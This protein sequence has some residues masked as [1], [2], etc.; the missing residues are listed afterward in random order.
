VS[1]HTLSLSLDH[2]ETDDLSS[3]F[4]QSVEAEV[5]TLSIWNVSDSTRTDNSWPPNATIDSISTRI[6]R[7]TRRTSRRRISTPRRT[8]LSTIPTSTSSRTSIS[9][10]RQP[11]RT[12]SKSGKEESGNDNSTTTMEEISISIST[13]TIHLLRPLLR[14]TIRLLLRTRKVSFSFFFYPPSRLQTDLSLLDRIDSF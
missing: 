4:F 14:T 9:R 10:K 2:T 8:V 11:R 5:G 13:I 7:S 1:F 6:L 12:T 3:V